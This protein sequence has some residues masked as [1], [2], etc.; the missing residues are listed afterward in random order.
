LGTSTS[1]EGKE[2]FSDISNHKK[3][4]VWVDDHDGNEIELAFSKKRIADRLAI[5][6]FTNLAGFVYA[7]SMLMC[8][9]FFS[10]ELTLTTVRKESSTV[11]S[12]TKS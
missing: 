8:K 2:Y 3:D 6:S 9:P 12:S 1:K 7:G 5:V 4:F 10:L 11:I